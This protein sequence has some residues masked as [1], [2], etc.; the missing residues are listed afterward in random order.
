[1]DGD[2]H[3]PEVLIF[4]FFCKYINGFKLD[5]F[6]TNIEYDETK[7]VLYALDYKEQLY[8]Y[9]LSGLLP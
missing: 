7:N 2:Y 6:V 9:D 4:F 5:R 8:A 3:V 1:M